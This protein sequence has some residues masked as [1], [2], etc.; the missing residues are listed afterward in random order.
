MKAV[1][2]FGDR[3]A[4][5]VERKDPEPKRGEVVVRMKASG[6]CGSDMHKY[7]LPRKEFLEQGFENLI[8]GHEPGGIVEEIGEGVE[9]VK[10]GDRVMVHHGAGCGYCPECLSGYHQ[11]CKKLFLLGTPPT[12]GSWSDLMLSRAIGCIKLPERLSFADGA[13]MGCTGGSVFRIFERLN[14]SAYDTVAI[15]GVGPLGLCAVLLGKAMGAR[16]L[17]VDLENERLDFAKKLGADETINA[18]TTNPVEAI[19]SLTK[20][21]GASVAID[22]SGNAT[23]NVLRSLEFGGRAGIIGLGHDTRDGFLLKTGDI[24]FRNLTLV[25][26][27]IFPI[28]TPR[29]MIDF[30]LLHNISLDTIVTHKFPLEKA[31]EALELFDTLKTGKIL[32]VW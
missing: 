26:N 17:A 21:K 28:D 7:R 6:I 4:A 2:F 29:K 31:L 5:I 25:G 13:I 27:L 20:Q 19:K 3:K 11:L 9:N 14:V 24:L 8:Q 23:A 16:T 1:V 32:F 18:V 22:F 12:D 10:E 30:L 15:Y